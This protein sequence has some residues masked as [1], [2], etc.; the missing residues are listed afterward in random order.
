MILSGSAA[1][2]ATSGFAGANPLRNLGGVPLVGQKHGGCGDA[3]P[4]PPPGYKWTDGWQN[5]DGTGI[6]MDL[7]NPL[8]VPFSGFT[9]QGGQASATATT[10]YDD[11]W[12]NVVIS[13][14][15]NYFEAPKITL[16]RNFVAG[17]TYT[18]FQSVDGN[19]LINLH[20]EGSQKNSWVSY[21]TDGGGLWYALYPSGIVVRKFGRYT[22]AEQR[23]ALYYGLNKNQ[24]L[25]YRYS[26]LSEKLYNEWGNIDDLTQ[27]QKLGI[28][29]ILAGAAAALLALTGVGAIV[30]LLGAFFGG[31]ST[32]LGLAAIINFNCG[33]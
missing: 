21:T 6:S 25:G 23:H 1:I 33:G 30:E 15:P 4:P 27:C 7:S 2:L 8:L 14:P 11:T 24:F 3:C 5:P 18:I 28:E 26:Y 29:T 19:T 32:G 16:P 12:A 20:W 9:P 17:Q 22:L 10:T 31:L 13:S